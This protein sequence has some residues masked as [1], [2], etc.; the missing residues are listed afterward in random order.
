[1]FLRLSC[2]AFELSGV[3]YQGACGALQVSKESI[4]SGLAASQLLQD[5]GLTVVT[6]CTLAE[7]P[8]IA[9]YM[10]SPGGHG[11]QG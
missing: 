7:Q 11:Q 8:A 5:T 10:P 2:A 9:K 6:G 4:V 3:V 1:M